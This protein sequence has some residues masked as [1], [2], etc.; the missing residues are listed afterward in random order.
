M[1]SHTLRKYP[2]ATLLIGA[3]LILGLVGAVRLLS[4]PEPLQ[5]LIRDGPLYESVDAL[6]K[7]SDVAVLGRVDRVVDSYLD[8]AGNPEFDERGDPLPKI[9]KLIVRVDVASTLVGDSLPG[10]IH[11]IVNDV[12]GMVDSYTPVLEPDQEIVLYL[13][14]VP[15][16]EG[17]DELIEHDS[18]YGGL[19]GVRGGNQG[20]FDVVDGRAT[21]RADTTKLQFDVESSYP[22]D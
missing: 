21:S 1:L 2:V 18:K 4:Q 15:A 7:E 8:P 10:E 19:F 13:F 11:V 20:V 22:N 12:S 3:G 5:V 9:P 16:E 14:D 6:R 17:S